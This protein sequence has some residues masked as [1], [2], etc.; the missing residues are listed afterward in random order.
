MTKYYGQK[1]MQ[2]L[3]ELTKK[4]FLVVTILLCVILLFVLLNAKIITI[5]IYS[6]FGISNIAM[7]EIAN[8][9]KFYALAYLGL[10]YYLIL[11][12]LFFSLQRVY[13]LVKGT[14]LGLL[15][16]IIVVILL[17]KIMGSMALPLAYT[18]Y[19]ITSTFYFFWILKKNV[20][21][22]EPPVIESYTLF[23]TFLFIIIAGVFSI[24]IPA[25]TLNIVPRLIITLMLILAFL[26]TVKNRF[27]FEFEYFKKF[28]FNIK[29]Q[30]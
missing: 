9:F 13:D 1:K 24:G 5:L 8:F 2:E 6:L 12:R 15:T 19:Y 4:S 22:R 7:I 26:F 3:Y 23:M 11:L 20:F 21:S 10:F 29:K 28:G 16:Y 14:L 25:E 30:K 17:K 18:A 27:L